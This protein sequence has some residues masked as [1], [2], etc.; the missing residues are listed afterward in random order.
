L[1]RTHVHPADAVRVE[2]LSWPGE[3]GAGG[4]DLTFTQGCQGDVGGSR[5][6]AGYG[7]FCLACK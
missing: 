1:S 3:Q 7:P 2:E 6:L 4:C 5:V